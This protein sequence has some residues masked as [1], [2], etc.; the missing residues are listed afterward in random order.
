[1]SRWAPTMSATETTVSAAIPRCSAGE[2]SLKRFFDRDMR[3]R[4]LRP[5]RQL[6]DLCADAVL[7]DV[8]DG[9]RLG[10]AAHE[11]ERDWPELGRDGAAAEVAH[12]PLAEAQLGARGDGGGQAQAA[13]VA[14]GLAL[15]V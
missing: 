15:V 11:R 8:H 12:D 13:Q 4:L 14:V 10:L 6:D 1:M 3:S 7:A 2:R 9:T 5:E